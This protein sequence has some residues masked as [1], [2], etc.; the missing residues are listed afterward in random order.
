MLENALE[1]DQ[2][3]ARFTSEQIAQY[4]ESIKQSAASTLLPNEIVSDAGWNVLLTNL[5]SGMAQCWGIK[6]NNELVGLV[7]TVFCNEP[8]LG[9][10]N[11]TVSA[12]VS[13]ENMR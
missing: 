2:I 10:K 9:T 5:M 8:T 12:L 1:E 11:L 4:W 7:I 6:V 13:Y 3:L